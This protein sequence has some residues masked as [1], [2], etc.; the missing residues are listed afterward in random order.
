MSNFSTDQHNHQEIDSRT[1]IRI[2]EYGIVPALVVIDVQNGFVSKS[3]SYD[4]LG[5]DISYYQKIIPTV[6]GLL[7][8]CKSIGI[9]IYFTNAIREPSGFDL[10]T[11]THK[12]LPQAREERIKDVPIC[13]RGT[14]DAEI[15]EEL[16]PSTSNIITKRRDSTFQGTNL[17]EELRSR[18]IDTVIFCGVDTSMCVESSVREA[19]N[20]GYDVVVVSDATASMN[21]SRYE[22]TLDDVKSFYGLVIE[23]RELNDSTVYRTQ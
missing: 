20:L 10:L 18:G 9:P 23:S 3:G 7:E 16:K 22:C 2:R 15:I 14:W 12:I 11:K 17:D 13:V 19:F 8:H 21:P 1:A 5:I 6:K 4:K